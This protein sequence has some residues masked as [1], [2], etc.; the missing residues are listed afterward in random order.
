MPFVD[1]RFFKGYG[2]IRSHISSTQECR[3]VFKFEMFSHLSDRSF[4]LRFLIRLEAL[5][6]LLGKM[7]CSGIPFFF[8]FFCEKL[9]KNDIP[10]KR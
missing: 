7:L 9:F 2:I 10:S 3:V 4:G 1:V 6:N 8:F 5:L